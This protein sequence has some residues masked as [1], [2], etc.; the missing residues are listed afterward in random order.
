MEQIVQKTR[1]TREGCRVTT[2][3]RKNPETSDMV[4]EE[5]TLQCEDL[6]EQHTVLELQEEDTG[7]W[8]TGGM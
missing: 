1:Y 2:V 4:V 6:T 3:V 8:L 7:R 5:I